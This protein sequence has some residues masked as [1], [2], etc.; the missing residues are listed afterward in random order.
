MGRSR[1]VRLIP[2][3]YSTKRKQSR[4]AALAEALLD[5]DIAEGARAR[6]GRDDG[7]RYTL[8][9]VVGGL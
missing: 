6:A 8:D 1:L 5:E 9:E 2:W 4:Q 7:R 3:Y